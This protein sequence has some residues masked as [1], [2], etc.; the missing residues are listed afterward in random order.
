LRRP[1]AIIPDDSKEDEDL[2]EPQGESDQET[3]DENRDNDHDNDDVADLQELSN[4]SLKQ[5]IA[6]EVCD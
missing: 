2:E 4:A 6:S 5:K 1:P 3:S